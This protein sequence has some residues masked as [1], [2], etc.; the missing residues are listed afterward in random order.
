ML[1]LL[2]VALGAVCFSA[3]LEREFLSDGSFPP[4]SHFRLLPFVHYPG[5]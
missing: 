2:L 3:G 1:L 5:C 4:K